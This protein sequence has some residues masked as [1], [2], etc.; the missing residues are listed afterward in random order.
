MVVHIEDERVP[1]V[2]H[3]NGIKHLPM[4]QRLHCVRTQGGHLLVAGQHP[5]SFCCSACSIICT[6]DRQIWLIT[7]NLNLCR[8][9][10]LMMLHWPAT[11]ETRVVKI[12]EGPETPASINEP[13]LEAS[14]GTTR[15]RIHQ[16]NH[17][18]WPQLFNNAKG[19]H[20]VKGNL[21]QAAC[22]RPQALGD[23]HHFMMSAL[24]HFITANASVIEDAGDLPV[25]WVRLDRFGEWLAE[26]RVLQNAQMWG[27]QLQ[28]GRDVAAQASA[29]AGLAAM[30]PSTFPIANALQAC[31]Q[32][33]TTFCRSD[34]D[35]DGLIKSEGPSRAG[36]QCLTS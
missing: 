14:T 3:M 12:G 22:C 13:I 4:H 10:D 33:S 5:Q 28:R 25:W 9:W 27:L 21:P 17:T 16:P 15:L 1:D 7:S 32:N 18:L 31:L 8:D 35:H 30:R 26:T 29:V 19:E 36:P 2:S 24:D 34:P 20:C 11:A 6:C 23:Q